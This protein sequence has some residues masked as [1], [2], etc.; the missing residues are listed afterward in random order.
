MIGSATGDPKTNGFIGEVDSNPWENTRLGVQYIGYS[1]FN[2]LST[3]YDGAGP[4]RSHSRPSASAPNPNVTQARRDPDDFHAVGR[5]P[6]LH[7][8]FTRRWGRGTAQAEQCD[9][10]QCDHSERALPLYP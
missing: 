2:G 3:N 6:A 5:R 1:N 4:N 10:S 8:Q 9:E 7:H